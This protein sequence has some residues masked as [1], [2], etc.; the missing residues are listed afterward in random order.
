M[1]QHYLT[2]I[3]IRTFTYFFRGIP[4]E[5]IAA[6]LTLL[7]KKN[8]KILEARLFSVDKQVQIV[9]TVSCLVINGYIYFTK[10]LK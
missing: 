8:I 4:N 10:I 5:T 3:L 1:K 2:Q 6:D 9:G 7:P